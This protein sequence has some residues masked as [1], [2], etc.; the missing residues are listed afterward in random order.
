ME[1]EKQHA[2]LITGAASGMGSATARLFAAK[3]VNVVLF[4][5]NPQVCDVAKD[6]AGIGIVCDVC[7][8]AA[9]KTSLHQ[10]L[11]QVSEIRVLINCAGIIS[12]GRVVGREGPL[13]LADFSRTLQ[14]NCVGNFNVLSQVAHHM[15]LLAAVNEDGEQGVIINTASIAAFD[16]Q[17]G[18]AAYSAS[19]GAVVAMT[20]PIARELARFGIRVMTIAPGV[21]DTAMMAGLTP[22]VQDSLAMQVPF[23]KRL[24]MAEEYAELVQHII[25]NAYLNGEVIRL[26]GGIRMQAK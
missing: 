15:S 8:E 17:I 7:D 21:V 26:D 5:V 1:L 22:D 23:P 6:I 12:S 13:P 16:G 19:K 10:A 4:D 11:E 9:V 18:Q 24:G 25:S 3:G 20:L 14:I 2:V